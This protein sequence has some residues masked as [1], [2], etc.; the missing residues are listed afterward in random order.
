MQTHPVLLA[1]VPAWACLV[2][3]SCSLLELPFSSPGS[4][5]VQPWLDK[6]LAVA[7]GRRP[8]L[9]DLNTRGNLLPPRAEPLG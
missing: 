2:L 5:L 3:T 1:P 6:K 9:T 4:R 7:K 8:S